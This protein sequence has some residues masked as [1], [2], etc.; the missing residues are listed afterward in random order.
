[1]PE[2][3]TF[4]IT[5]LPRF[6][7]ISCVQAS[8][9]RADID[10]LAR[11]A[12]ESN[13]VSAH[14]LPNWVPYLRDRLEGSQTLV[15]SPVGFPSGGATTAT[16]V[17][18]AQQLL[19]AGAQE[20]DV[21]VNIGRL[22]SADTGYVTSELAQIA[23]VVDGAVP[24]R[25]ILEVGHLTEEEIRLGCDCAVEAGIDWVKTATGWSGVPST[26]EH[27]RIIADQLAGRARMKAAGGIRDL[28]TVQAMADLGVTRFGM[29]ATVAKEL[30]QQAAEAE[31]V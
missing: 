11:R 22:R 20:L 7:D 30:A 19:D 1:M 2:Q 10:E 21:V 12:R 4:S 26:V 24:L 27:I 16:K 17:F 9:N 14:V 25:A 3:P 29:N 13:F 31:G 15:G 5:Q 23:A 8:H 6:V 18:E 28:K